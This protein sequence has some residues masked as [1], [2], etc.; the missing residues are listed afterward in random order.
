M[1]NLRQYLFDYR[2]DW[3]PTSQLATSSVSSP[4]TEVWKHLECCL[5][6]HKWK[7]PAGLLLMVPC[8][9]VPPSSFYHKPVSHGQRKFHVVLV[10]HHD[11]C[12]SNTTTIICM[13]TPKKNYRSLETEM[14]VCARSSGPCRSCISRLPPSILPRREALFKLIQPSMKHLLIPPLTHEN[15][16]EWTSA[17]M[18]A[19]ISSSFYSQALLVSRVP[20]KC[21]HCGS[22]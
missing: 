17:T 14:V 15:H 16:N 18:A 22:L 2:N 7:R 8:T 9:A 11:L 1:G 3:L 5:V 20:A 4:T 12:H 10:A 6:C 21:F 19:L 13:E